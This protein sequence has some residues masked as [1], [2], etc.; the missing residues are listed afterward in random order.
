VTIRA[1]MV[2]VDGV[3]VR[4]P[5]GHRWDRDILADLGVDPQ[6]LQTQFF[7][8]H[9]DDI[10][11][12]RAGLMDRL[13]P[14]L[15]QFAP[16]VPAQ[17]LVDYWFAK[18][19]QLD[20]TLLAD[21]AVLRGQGLALHLATVQEHLRADHLWNRL[22]LKDR[23]DAIHYAAAYGSKKPDAAF[24]DAVCARTGL[25][26]GEVVLIDDSPRNVEGAR[27]CGWA[28]VLWDGT[29]PLSEV[30]APVVGEA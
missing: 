24:F 13:G 10:V 28:A 17:A 26:P 14:A 30:L 23:F 15:A 5:E 6:A 8:P 20:E 3:V 1:L 11:L 7:A 12:G 27:A 18:D 22:G 9:F 21:L 25:A 4:H 19:A 29:R 2:D 16:H